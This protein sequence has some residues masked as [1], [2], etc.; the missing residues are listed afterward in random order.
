MAVGRYYFAEAEAAAV[1]PAA[2]AGWDEVP[3]TP[4]F[5]RLIPATPD[6]STLATVDVNNCPAGDHIADYD[7]L[8]RTYVSDLLAAQTILSTT[9]I[10]GQFQCLESN[11]GNNLFLTMKVW[12][13][14]A[15]GAAKE[16]L[17]D[18]SRKGTEPTTSIRNTT[19]AATALNGSGGNVTVEATDRLVLEIGLGGSPVA[20]GGTQSHRGSIRWGG[21]ATSGDLPEDEST[22]TATYRP[23][24]ELS[25]DITFFTVT[26]I[27]VPLT[28]DP[29]GNL[30]DSPPTI[31]KPGVLRATSAAD[32]WNNEADVALG[33][34]ADHYVT[35]G[36]PW[37]NLDDVSGVVYDKQD[38]AAGPTPITRPLTD[39]WE[40]LADSLP[41][42]DERGFKTVTLAADPWGNLA[43]VAPA[44]DERGAL[45][46]SL[47]DP[48]QNLADLTPTVSK[49]DI[50]ATPIE[51]NLTADPWGNLGDIAPTIDERGFRTLALAADPWGN[52]ADVTPTVDER[53]FIA[54]SL[55]PDSLNNWADSPP[56]ID[57]PGFADIVRNLTPDNLAN[58]GERL[59]LD[60]LKLTDSMTMAD[61][62]PTL[63]GD[64]LVT[65]EDAWANL[66]DVSGVTYD[67]QDVVGGATPKT[68]N[69]SDANAAYDDALE[70]LRTATYLATP[71]D[72]NAWADSY[73]R[74]HAYNLTGD[75]MVMADLTPTIS[76]PDLGT[77][78]IAPSIPADNWG[79]LGDSP[80]TISERGYLRI[81]LAADP[82][83]NLNDQ[84][85]TI[86]ERGFKTVTLAADP[87]TQ[88][89]SL[90]LGRGWSL[91]D[92]WANLGDL[93]PSVDKQDIV[94]TP[95]PINVPADAWA[96]L[97]DQPATVAMT[98]K[99]EISLTPDAMV[100]GDITPNVAA[101]GDLRYP[102]AADNLANY[103]ELLAHSKS[104]NLTG[105]TL[106]AYDDEVDQL[107]LAKRY[108]LTADPWA[109][110]ADSAP[111]I[112]KMAPKTIVPPADAKPA[113]GE[114]LG[115]GRSFAGDD[116]NQ[117]DDSLRS[118]GA[119]RLSLTD[120]LANYQDQIQL[121]AGGD[122]RISLAADS[123]TMG[124]QPIVPNYGKSYAPTADAMT[125]ADTAVDHTVGKLIGL[126]DNLAA[127]AETLGEGF[128]L[129]EAMP[130]YADD[131]AIARIGDLVVE[132]LDAAEA[133][134]DSADYRLLAFYE[135]AVE[136]SESLDN[137]AD[138]AA[139]IRAIMAIK[140]SGK[141]IESAAVNGEILDDS[142][143][144]NGK[145]G[146]DTVSIEG[147]FYQGV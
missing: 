104:Y 70:I 22:A 73:R 64:H 1:S 67:K 79:N 55:S 120:N 40:N 33:L 145:V 7:S 105:D 85:P 46:F 121:T 27:T 106:A 66:N 24:I 52:L 8:H 122:L 94:A 135:L 60:Y 142:V 107:L 21:T 141:L 129:I 44:V 49:P 143:A 136:V 81:A 12:L 112:S 100:M 57:K 116:L 50:S 16:L 88:A 127:Y 146:D 114:Q 26:P 78:P 13:C 6:G 75:A 147:E 19:F 53:G 123:M 76:K 134:Q 5:R 15:D 80:P 37:A 18:I 2:S 39:P 97:N 35:F 20:T 125:M 34:K 54:I 59:G 14:D 51:R 62:A 47:T 102:L 130:A 17:L 45:A 43:D 83:A 36:D 108:P 124:D 74:S 71:D 10:K 109:N 132:L 31:D 61:V 29:W 42:I 9:T 137:W 65:F 117:W 103:A 128:G 32:P 38:A 101:G 139:F 95:K 68:A 77:T 115:T 41:T 3:G 91:T 138:A 113:F 131:L 11:A 30:G 140:V 28:D 56:T 82:W 63:I 87:M 133:Y 118:F 72:L 90:G 4:V 84:S 89:D 144:L 99:L 93:T 126:T 48:W 86:D 25:N 119:L 96:T 58:Y 23:W 92:S 69:V 111:T 110:L 98:G